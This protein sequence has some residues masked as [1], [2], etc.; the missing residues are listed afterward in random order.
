MMFVHGS[1]QRRIGFIL[2][3]V[4]NKQAALTEPC[5]RLLARGT[6]IDVVI[7]WKGGQAAT[8]IISDYLLRAN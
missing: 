8:A 7:G 6:Q 2:C 5:A 4:K 3:P 1:I